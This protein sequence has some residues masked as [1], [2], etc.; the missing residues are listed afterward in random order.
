MELVSILHIKDS[1]DVKEMY[2][3]IYVNP[4]NGY[5]K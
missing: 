3:K 1:K 4:K 2:D 5:H